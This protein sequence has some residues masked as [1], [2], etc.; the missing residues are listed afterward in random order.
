MTG[1]Q[2]CALPISK[3]GEGFYVY[4]RVDPQFVPFGTKE[5]EI[6]VVARR[7]DNKPVGISLLYESLKGYKGAGAKWNIPEGE[8]WQ[9][10]TW[11]VQ[12]AN[13]VGGWGW[14]FRTDGGGGRNDF[15]IKEVRVKKTVK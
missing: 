1:V 5:L 6:T 11:K 7:I 15:L 10:N 9:E 4:F 8:Q 12:D 13:F 2:T 14:N 3:G